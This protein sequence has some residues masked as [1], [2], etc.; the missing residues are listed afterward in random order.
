MFANFDNEVITVVH[1]IIEACKFQLTPSCIK[2]WFHVNIAKQIIILILVY[3]LSEMLLKRRV[4]ISC[5]NRKGK[6]DGHWATT[7]SENRISMYPVA[8]NIITDSNL[9]N[10]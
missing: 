2:Y 9:V 10:S 3:Q 1:E 6:L 5:S 7:V 8:Q 4:K